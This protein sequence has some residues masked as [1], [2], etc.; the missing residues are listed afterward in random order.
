MM[1]TLDLRAREKIRRLRKARKLTLGDLANQCNCSKSFLSRVETGAVNPSLATLMLIAEALEVTVHELF[2]EKKSEN[3]FSHCVVP[4][5][6][7]KTLLLKDDIRIQLLS[8][9][10]ETPYEFMLVRFPPETTDGIRIFTNEEA[11]L[12]T[13]E[14]I[15]CGIVIQGELD[16][17]VEDKVYRLKPGESITL[18]SNT[19]HKISNSGKEEALAIWVDSKPVFFTTT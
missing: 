19:P 15:E 10:M 5:D 9:G 16:V 4:P 2:S 6:D 11:D 1:T 3:R 7:R 13:H 8:R 17:H 12:H 18:N 14:G